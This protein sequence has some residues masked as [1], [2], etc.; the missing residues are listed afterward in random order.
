K[1][2]CGPTGEPGGEPRHTGTGTVGESLQPLPQRPG[3]YQRPMTPTRSPTP[4]RP[5]PQQLTPPKPHHNPRNPTPRTVRVL[6]PLHWRSRRGQSRFNP[7]KTARNTTAPSTSRAPSGFLESR[8][9]TPSAQNTD[10]D[11]FTA[12]VV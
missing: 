12:L 1:P 5:G 6:R 11:A 3:S 2:N 8:T 9:P 4:P 10:L 7:A